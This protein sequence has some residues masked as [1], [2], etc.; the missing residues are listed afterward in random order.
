MP[1]KKEAIARKSFFSEKRTNEI[2]KHLKDSVAEHIRLQVEGKLPFA[3]RMPTVVIEIRHIMVIL[4]R[5]RNTA[6]KV[7]KE[8]REKL[9]K[10]P[11]QKVSVTE[12]CKET[13][14]PK[15]EVQQALDL[16]T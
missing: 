12:F 2:I 16:L 7:M 1:E 4:N 14:L 13:G 6:H 11:G 15:M 9:E 10:K 5:K 3:S 8:I